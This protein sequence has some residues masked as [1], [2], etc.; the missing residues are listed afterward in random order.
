MQNKT[1]YAT[2]TVFM[3]DLFAATLAVA[4]H[5]AT[6]APVCSP[7]NP[8]VCTDSATEGATFASTTHFSTTG[9]SNTASSSVGGCLGIPFLAS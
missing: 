1:A 4:V 9:H 2:I 5:A 6:A 3:T 7:R 8:N